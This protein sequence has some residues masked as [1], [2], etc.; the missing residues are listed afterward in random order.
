MK[1]IVGL[2]NPGEKYNNTRHNVGFMVLDALHQELAPENEWKK[3]NKHNTLVIK[4]KYNNTP[5]LLA[6][7]LTFM[8]DSGTAVATLSKMHKIAHHNIIIVHD[9]LDLSLG[10]IK[11]KKDGGSAGHNG[12]KSIIEKLRTED[13]LRVRLGIGRP[14]EVAE[15]E[16]KQHAVVQFVLDTFESFEQRE[17]DEAVKK[18]KKMI[19]RLVEYGYGFPSGKFYTKEEN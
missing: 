13:F 1:L 2:G 18:A 17:V 12:L 8:N 11:V 4:T 16:Q 14:K 9:D 6:K 10:Q 19:L 15:Y 7:P 3:E 5:L